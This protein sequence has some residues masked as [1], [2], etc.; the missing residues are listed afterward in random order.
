MNILFICSAKTWGGN[1]KWVSLVMDGL[2]KSHNI[3]FLGKTPLLHSRFGSDIPAFWAPFKWTFDWRTKRIISK[4]VKAHS[5]DVIVSTKKKEYFLGGL[6]ARSFGIKHVLRLGIVRNMRVPF[7]SRLVYCRLNDGIIVNAH[8]IKSNLLKYKCFQ[9]HPV[10]VVYNG[11]PALVCPK[12]EEWPKLFTIISTGMLTRRKGFHILIEAILKLPG[13]LKSR[14]AVHILGTGREEKQLQEMIRENEL[15]D[16]VHLHGFC[17]PVEWLSRA[18]IFC[19]LSENEGI[20]NALLEAMAC[21]IPVLTTDAGGA[22][23]FI[24]E[25]ENGYLVPRN[26][27]QVSGKISWLM[28]ADPR[29]LRKTGEDGR[30]TV[31]SRFNMDRMVKE[32]EMFLHNFT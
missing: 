17:D 31:E 20:S 16:V 14:V 28:Q 2:K 8:R 27:Q 29:R 15:Q 1:E 26:A 30:L 9:E 19:L 18:N 4:I 3:Y 13:F 32:V 23:E 24:R 12:H 22:S 21:G 11:L 10:Q 7:W 5:V 25:G 6:V